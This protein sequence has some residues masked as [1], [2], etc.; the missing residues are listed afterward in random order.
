M[1]IVLFIIL[2]SFGQPNLPPV[3][4]G[5]RDRP[6][7][8]TMG[9]MMTGWQNAIKRN[10]LSSLRFYYNGVIAGKWT[11]SP[12]YDSIEE[13]ENLIKEKESNL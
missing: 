1:N 9:E 3:I 4:T 5:F 7:E 2:L 10:E 11:L 13:L 8:M 12:I 6:K